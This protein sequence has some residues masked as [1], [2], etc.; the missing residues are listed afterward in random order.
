MPCQLVQ[1]A[2]AGRLIAIVRVLG[3]HFL[4]ERGIIQVFVSA[5]ICLTNPGSTGFLKLVKHVALCLVIRPWASFARLIVVGFLDYLMLTSVL[6]DLL[7]QRFLIGIDFSPAFL[8]GGCEC[9]FLLLWS[10]VVRYGVERAN[11]C[12]LRESTVLWN[13]FALRVCNFCN[14]ALVEFLRSVFCNLFHPISVK[15]VASDTHCG[16]NQG[17]HHGA[18]CPPSAS[19]EPCDKSQQR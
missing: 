15:Q 19:P 2:K 10:G 8:F 5:G 9:F 4:Y 6:G 13:F 12:A 14:G 1:I 16:Q 17:G 11:E 18:E 3:Q 7:M